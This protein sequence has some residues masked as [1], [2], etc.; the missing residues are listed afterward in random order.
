MPAPPRTRPTPAQR[1][2]A[3]VELVPPAPVQARHAVLADEV[4]AGEGLLSRGDRGVVDPADELVGSAPRLRL[5]LAH[6]HVQA[7]AEAQR[8]P[9]PCRRG[10]DCCDLLGH[11]GERL[12]PGQVDV[13]VLGRDRDAGLGRAAEVERRIGLLDRRENDPSV[14]DRE[15][16]AL[17][18]R[19]S[20]RRGAR[21]RCA[22][23]S[24]VTA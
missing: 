19:R 16:L 3:I 17:V 20:R 11:V 2:G 10:A 1:L 5:R 18:G 6:D 8:A 24:S 4:V 9:A 15:V 22:R 14:F 12:A 7:D 21:A 13:D 23:N